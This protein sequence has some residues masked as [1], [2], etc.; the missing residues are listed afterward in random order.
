MKRNAILL[1][2]LVLLAAT[3]AAIF[4]SGSQ[5]AATETQAEPKELRIR[6][7]SW[8]VKKAFIKEA[9]E[10]FMAANPDVKL[11]VES[12][13][14]AEVEKV[15]LMIRSGESPADLFFIDKV[16]NVGF[17]VTQDLLY[18]FDELGYFKLNP[19]SETIPAILETGKVRDKHYFLP[20]LYE[21]FGFNVNKS[22]FVEAGVV[23]P[24][25]PMPKLNNWDEVLLY[26]RKVKG[27]RENGFSIRMHSKGGDQVF[28][29]SLK[30]LTGS[31]YKSGT[32]L[33]DLDNPA[34]R[35]FMTNWKKGVD[36]GIYSTKPFTDANAGRKD[37]KAEKIA[38]I[39]ESMSRWQE[40]ISLIGDE[41]AI[42]WLPPGDA[43][44]GATMTSSFYMIPKT[45]KAPKLAVKFITDTHYTEKYQRKMMID[46]GK[47][48]SK[49]E[50]HETIK[51]PR[52]QLMADVAENT[53]TPPYYRGFKQWWTDSVK[54]IQ[55]YLLGKDTLGGTLQKMKAKLDSIDKSEF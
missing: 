33:I 51:D 31:I 16:F 4:A 34:I 49:M 30:Y 50:V 8:L 53:I 45:S 20:F 42:P 41:N 37:Y 38:I 44:N 12:L 15:A 9:T 7:I 48:P 36:E 10:D 54:Y 32:N 18:S 21:P 24:N 23:G 22:M 26:A 13:D 14:S 1:F 52:F 25:D 27:D 39:Y 2:V 11:T 40:A 29:T 19:K 35:D 43:K 46:F 47:M 5:D 6:A 17:F 28:L 3:V 55:A